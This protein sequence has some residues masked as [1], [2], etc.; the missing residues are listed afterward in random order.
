MIVKVA[1]A[2]ENGALHCLQHGDYY[3]ER[4]N[5]P[6]NAHCILFSELSLLQYPFEQFPSNNQLEGE[7]VLGARFE[8]FVKFDLLPWSVTA[9][10]RIEVPRTI[11]G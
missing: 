2:S 4:C 5:T 11:F 3:E 9:R 8:P 1:Y 7:V 6:Y 10:A